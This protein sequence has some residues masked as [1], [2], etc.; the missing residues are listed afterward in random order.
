MRNWITIAFMALMLAGCG[1]A[2]GQDW[3]PAATPLSTRWAAKVDPSAP[4]P[5]YP[6]P[7]MVR[8]QWKNLNGLWEFAPAKAEEL[9]PIGRTLDRKIL[10]P[11]P[12]ESS[13]SGVGEHHP[14]L[15]YRRLFTVPGYWADRRVMLHFGAVDFHATV[16]VNGQLMGEHKGGYDPFSFDITDAIKG[17]GDQ[18]VVV[19]VYDPTNKGT[20]SRGK[21]VLEVMN[22]PQGIYYTPTTGIWQ[23]VWMEPVSAASILNYKTTTLELQRPMEAGGTALLRYQVMTRG[24]G[25]KISVKLSLNGREMVSGIAQAT[26]SQTT[27]EL[28]VPQPKLWT[29]DTPT[30]YQARIAFLDGAGKELDVVES[31]TGIRTITV[32]KDEKGVTRLL[33]NGKFVFHMGPLDQGFWPDGLYTAPTEE[34]LLYDIQVT[35]DLGFNMIRKHVKVEPARWYHH[36]DRLGLLVWQDIP[37]GDRSIGSRDPDL[38]RSAPAKAQFEMEMKAIIEANYNSPSIVMWVVFNEGWGQYE[39]PR[40]TQMA[41]DLDPQRLVNCA[42]GWS[43]RG[44]GDVHDWHVY[45]GP[46]SPKPEEKRAAVLGEFGGIA[47]GVDGHNWTQK[48]WGYQTSSSQAALTDRY[49]QLQFGVWKLIGD[50]GLSA[51]VYTQTTD[52]EAEANG[53]MTYDRAIIKMD[54]KRVAEANRRLHTP[55]PDIKTILPTSTAQGQEWRYTTDKPADKWIAADFDDKAWK[56]GPGGFGTRITPNTTVRTE[57]N[58]KDIWLR[59]SVELADPSQFERIFLNVYHDEDA[60]IYINGVKAAEF[61]GYVSSYQ[62]IVLSAEGAKALKAGRN[63][64]AIHCKQTTGGQ[65]IDLGL[66]AQMK[67]GK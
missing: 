60:E 62:L 34:A 49:D 57:W 14:R 61:K 63:I 33:L 25:D 54:S 10:V 45:P 48:T 12:V 42:S 50:P 15:W 29:P 44:V 40:I 55:F 17:D 65:Y 24:R 30:L 64:I 66:E 58:T 39:T 41:K 51:A 16:W 21:Q 5:E 36:C 20:Q 46:G 59:R 2:A 13:L 38:N 4:L 35:K 6:R 52:V 47:L 7:Q 67:P 31:Y 28:L 26:G 37:S 9:P 56:T 11:Y 53:L 18:E 3:K 23:T 8:K 43:D 1:A 22:K 32:G 19:G 27:L